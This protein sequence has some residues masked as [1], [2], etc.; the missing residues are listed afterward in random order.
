MARMEALR[1]S[2]G[3]ETAKIP[4]KRYEGSIA[5]NSVEA[6]K[7]ATVVAK[8]SSGVSV[9]IGQTNGV[10]VLHLIKKTGTSETIFHAWQWAE[11]PWNSQNIVK[12][13]A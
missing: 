12:A 11:H 8:Q 7:L 9:K 3:V 1:G 6:R 5:M 4:S 13:A 10:A 2:S